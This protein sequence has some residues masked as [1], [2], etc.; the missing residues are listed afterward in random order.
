M[1]ENGWRVMIT[2]TVK[3]QLVWPTVARDSRGVYGF[4]V[5]A[6]SMEYEDSELLKVSMLR[7]IESEPISFAGYKAGNMGLF[8][9][10]SNLITRLKSD[11][12]L[13]KNSMGL[14]LVRTKDN[15]NIVV[16]RPSENVHEEAVYKP[17]SI[18][19]TM[20]ELA[21]MIIDELRAFYSELK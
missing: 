9:Y 12:S 20:E 5:P 11:K 15:Y 4:M 17:I 10:Q 19:A 6:H 21:G 14:A 16:T 3:G 18:D 8:G 1:K 7:L 13:R 2:A